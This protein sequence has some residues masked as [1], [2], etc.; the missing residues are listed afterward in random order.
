[1]KKTSLIALTLASAPVIPLTA[2]DGSPPVVTTEQSATPGMQ[3][4]KQ[5]QE[6]YTKAYAAHLSKMRAAKDNATRSE[7]YQSRP[8]PTKVVE[9]TLAAAKSNPKADG[10]EKALIWSLRTSDKNQRSEVGELL[11]T[12]YSG[13]K[14][15]DRLAQS[16]KFNEAKL[17]E[18][19]TR[20]TNEIVR[21]NSTYYL[22]ANMRR[23]ADKKEQGHALLNELKDWPEIAEK[24]PKLLKLVTGDLFSIEKLSIGATAPEIVGNDHD[25]K[26]FKLSDYRG[27]V[28]LLDFW[29][30]W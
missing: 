8:L 6:A 20:S 26:E 24:N 14:S 16:W 23:S 4:I 22:A 2:Q 13:S 15:V 9:H 28:V 30:H 21:Q 1:M 19:I 5:A 10:I 17:R 25:D 3:E 12:H 7:L 18:I 27:Q 29:G 11:L